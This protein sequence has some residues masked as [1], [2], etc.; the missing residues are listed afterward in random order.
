[1]NGSFN[2]T[3]SAVK[4]NNENVVVS[5]DPA[6]AAEFTRQFNKLWADFA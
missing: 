4:E 1:M 6:L 3:I 2:W 5:R